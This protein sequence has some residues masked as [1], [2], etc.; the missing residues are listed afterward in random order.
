[1]HYKHGVLE[2]TETSVT[3]ALGTIRVGDLPDP[4][5]RHPLRLSG[6]PPLFERL[7]RIALSDIEANIV[8]VAAGT[9]FGAGTDFGPAVYTRDISYAGVLGLNRLYPDIMRSSIEYSRALRREVGFAV[10]RGHVVAE[11][12]VDWKEQDLSGAEFLAK[13][14]TNCY[15][16]RTDDVIWL[17]AM[18]D[19][20][21]GGSTREDWQWVYDTGWEF[22]ETFYM[23]FFEPSDGLFR[24]QSSFVDVH[25]DGFKAT[26]YPQDW[27]IADCV[28]SQATSTN[29]LYVKGMETMTRAC[30]EIG[31]M[32][33]ANEWI[34]KGQELSSEIR[35]YLRMPDGHFVYLRDRDGAVQQR[36]HALGEALAV[37]FGI[38]SGIPRPTPVCPCSIRSSMRTPSTTTTAP[39]RSWIRCISR[40]SRWRWRPH[41]PLPTRWCWR[42]RVAATG[43]FT[44]WLTC[45]TVP[46]RARAASCGPRPPSSTCAAGRG[47]SSCRAIAAVRHAARGVCVRWLTGRT[48]SSF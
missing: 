45:A 22:F 16:R 40:R 38:V 18:G 37:L 26:G 15:T 24:G 44:S 25:F 43:R 8:T 21:V 39:G 34:T 46:Y 29:C 35:R 33:E 32:D 13:Y 1:M 27:S 36:R 19:L 7:W 47:W 30:M 14:H 42:A 31:K 11:I 6:V 48:Y 17:W 9:Y 2:L 20:L 5:P 23:P 28:M 41:I 10:P 12:D 3:D 4:Q